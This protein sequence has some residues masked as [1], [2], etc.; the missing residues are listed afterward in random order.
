[1]A[2]VV[3]RILS[4]VGEALRKRRR[5]VLAVSGGVDSMVLLDAAASE[6][7][8]DRIVVATFD[9]G[10]GAAATRAANL[11][12]SRSAMLGVAC[13]LGTESLNGA[14]EAVMRAARWSFL[15]EVAKRADGD[16]VTA[17]HADDQIE[18]VLMRTLRDAGARG[19]AGLAA[20]G[21][22]RRPLLGVRRH[23]IEAYARERGLEWV[24]DPSNSSRRFFR[25]RI[26]HDV[27]P[28]LRVVWPEADDFFL[29][30]GSRAAAW[31][32]DVDA[33]IAE[34]LDVRLME[35]RKGLDVDANALGR[36][37]VFEL[38]EILPAVLARA[39][40]VLDRRGIIRLVEFARHSR[41]GSRMQLSGD[42]QVVR[43]RDALQLRA[44]TDTPPTPTALALSESTNWAVWRFIP[45][46]AERLEDPWRARL[47]AGRPL[48]IR[49]WRRGDVMI[50]GAARRT[51]KVKELLS[52][53]GVTGHDRMNWPV[54]TV[55]DDIIWIPGVRRSEVAAD[56][57]G[58]PWLSFLCEYLNR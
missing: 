40:C 24:E 49:A 42:W 8:A 3:A 33:F 58:Q 21:N 35:T 38:R 16:L 18:T 57:A 26:R 45:T 15:R 2:P 30:L 19:L 25:N 6:L 46:S 9:H 55:G 13:E 29:R 34:K 39:G 43:S 4:E 23:E 54:V 44:S 17:H 12:R 51:R 11:V 36:C 41:V 5:V 14:S 28:A 47:P 32:R 37:S 20:P 1:M 7:P 52:R 22:V 53:A 27:L 48:T 31:R 50:A 56:S 10:T